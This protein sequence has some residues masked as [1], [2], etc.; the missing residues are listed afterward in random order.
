MST[1]WVTISV[2]EMTIEHYAQQVGVTT[3]TVEGWVAKGLIPTTKLGRR[4]LINVAARAAFCL[5]ESRRYR[6]EKNEV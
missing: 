3:R 1:D 6:E 4:R 2:P 5:N